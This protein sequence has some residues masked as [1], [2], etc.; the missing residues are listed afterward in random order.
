MP[1]SILTRLDYLAF[2][3]YLNTSTSTDEEFLIRSYFGMGKDYLQLAIRRA[4]RD[5]NRTLHGFG[6]LPEKDKI[7]ATAGNQLE[8]AFRELWNYRSRV[9]HQAVFDS[10][11]QFTSKKLIAVYLPYHFHFYVGQAQKWINMTFKYIFTLGERRLPGY[12]ALYPFCH[13]SLDNILI[14]A[15]AKNGFPDLAS[16]LEPHRRL[17]CLFA[18]SGM[19]ARP[20]PYSPQDTESFLWWKVTQTSSIFFDRFFPNQKTW[21]GL[22][23]NLSFTHD[24]AFE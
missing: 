24:C 20:F 6:S 13:V 11:H 22:I 16:P 3:Q 18:S 9:I 10:W 17:Y 2:L 21:F 15:L 4:Y 19:C 1:E 8:A 23:V 5:F 7:R 14:A 12:Q